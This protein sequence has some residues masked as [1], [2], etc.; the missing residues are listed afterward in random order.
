MLPPRRPWRQV[1]SVDPDREYVAFTS[2]FFLRS[3]LRAPSFIRQS[4]RIMRQADAA[5]GVVGWS[6][7]ANLPKLEFFTL[8]AWEDAASLRAFIGAGDHGA[9]LQ[10][11]A[12]DM[13]R[14]SIFVQ[15]QVIGR[16][17]P[18]AWRDAVA[19]QDVASVKRRETTLA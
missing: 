1:A 16:D 7:G 10:K 13:R 9:A 15:F 5:P 2:R 11:F 14:D 8:S 6:L 12:H 18:L 4:L 17:L 19:R 3:P